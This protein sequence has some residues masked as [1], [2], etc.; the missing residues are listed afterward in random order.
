[1]SAARH[2]RQA[3]AS[4]IPREQ[5][6]WFIRDHHAGHAGVRIGVGHDPTGQRHIGVMVRPVIS[7]VGCREAIWYSAARMA[8]S[9]AAFY[10]LSATNLTTPLTNWGVVSTNVFDNNGA[11]SV[12][13][14]VSPGVPQR[15]SSSSSNRRPARAAVHRRSPWRFLKRHAS[16]TAGPGKS[17]GG[18]FTQAIV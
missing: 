12:T 11:F 10:V 9:M 17:S 5:L 6:P 3:I 13:N 8:S 7:R 4:I 2:W 18:R 15:F 1:M 14:A 16:T